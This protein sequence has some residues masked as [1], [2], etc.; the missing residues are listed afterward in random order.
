MK[1]TAIGRWLIIGF[2]VFVILAMVAM[3]FLPVLQ[4]GITQ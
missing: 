3:P 4:T 1:Q 2:V